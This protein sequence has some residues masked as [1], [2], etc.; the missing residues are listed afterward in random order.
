MAIVHIYGGLGNQMFQYAFA[1]ALSRKK[2]EVF[3]LDINSFEVY[4]LRN[5]GLEKF[6]IHPV[7]ASKKEVEKLKYKNIHLFS[8]LLHKLKIKM[9]TFSNTYYKEQFSTFDKNVYDTTANTYFEGYWQSEK[10]FKEYRDDLLKRF[11]LKE[12]IHILSQQYK[13]GIESTESISLHVRRGDYVTNIQTNSVHGTCTLDYYKNAVI[14][15]EKKVKKPHFFLFGDDLD[16][17]K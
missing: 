11:V 10:Y 16:W 8:K 13:Q 9:M 12:K 17:V 14:E 2:N 4:D 7:F 15:I 1:Y 3:K 6:N 5:Y